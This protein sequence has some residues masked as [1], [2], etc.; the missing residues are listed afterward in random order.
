MAEEINPNDSASRRIIERS[1]AVF[2]PGNFR[3]GNRVQE[4][5]G[6]DKHRAAPKTERHF[7]HIAEENKSHD[8]AIHRLQVGNKC[9]AEGRKLAHYGYPGNVAKGGAH[10]AKQY[11]VTNIC[12]L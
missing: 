3:L 10:R 8:D 6:E 12:G 11:Q 1:T 4:D 5:G 2:A 7:V 9:N